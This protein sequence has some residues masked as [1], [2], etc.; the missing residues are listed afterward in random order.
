MNNTLSYKGFT[1][2]IEFSGDDEVFVGRV[3]GIN[4]VIVFHGKNVAELRRELKESIDFY[5]EV[6]ERENKKAEK[7]YSGKV[8]L[9]LPADL[10]ARI[11]KA[12]ASKGKSLN[13]WGREILESAV[14]T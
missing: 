11:A 14:K 5:L 9:R 8:F 13:E 2:T 6:C 4:D 10:H 7:Q 12:A 3:L 1:A